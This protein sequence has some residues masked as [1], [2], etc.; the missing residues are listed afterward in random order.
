MP[1]P[2]LLRPLDEIEHDGDRA[3]AAALQLR[4]LKLSIRCALAALDNGDTRLARLA[5]EVAP[6]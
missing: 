4:R 2:T 5:L 1:T 3:E 6:A